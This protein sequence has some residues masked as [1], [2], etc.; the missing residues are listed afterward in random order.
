VE[1]VDF[2]AIQET[3]LE[4]VP[5]SL[6]ANIW[7]NC[8]YGWTFLPATG[9]SGGI[10]SIWN[11]VKA[12]LVFTFFGVGFVGVCLDLIAEN[13]RCY[14]VN[15]Y[16]KCHI[17]DTRRLWD[18][19]CMSKSGFGDRLWCVVGDFNSVRNATKRKGVR[20]LSLNSRT[21]EM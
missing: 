19:I 16:A 15:V 12:S 6:V 1:K 3:K 11:K 14:I 8:D 13:R 4:D 20:A 9:N 2:L 7:G 5:E 21:S 10:L 18:D 17:R